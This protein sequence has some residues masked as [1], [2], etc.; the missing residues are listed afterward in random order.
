[1]PVLSRP[2]AGWAGPPAVASL[3]KPWPSIARCYSADEVP[4]KGTHHL[5][6]SVTEG[7]GVNQKS[8]LPKPP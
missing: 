2:H 6:I 4:V 1:M 3:A 5:K 8:R 7:E